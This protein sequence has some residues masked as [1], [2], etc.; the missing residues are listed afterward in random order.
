MT[1]IVKNV[2]DDKKY[3]LIGA[4]FGAFQSKK[5]NRFFGDLKADIEEGQY[6]M[7]CV[8]DKDGKIDWLESSNLEVV[9]IDGEKPYDLL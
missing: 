2:A 6:T 5:P 4:G 1:V 8:C 3:L 7:V 9:S